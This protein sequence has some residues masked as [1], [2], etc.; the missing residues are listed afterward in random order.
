M[1]QSI[2]VCACGVYSVRL[3]LCAWYVS[4]VCV[5]G[6]RVSHGLRLRYV[7]MVLCGVHVTMVRVRVIQM[8]R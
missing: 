1:P 8:C 6:I 4:M 2:V 3:V 5:C 7:S